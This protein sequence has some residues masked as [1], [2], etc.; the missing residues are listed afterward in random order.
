V[1]G[2]LNGLAANGG[3]HWSWRTFIRLSHRAS[4]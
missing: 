1:F 3:R 4:G 2:E